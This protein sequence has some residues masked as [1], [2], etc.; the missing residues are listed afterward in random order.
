[1]KVFLSATE[2]YQNLF[3][4]FFYASY[5]IAN[6]EIFSSAAQRLKDGRKMFK[7]DFQDLSANRKTNRESSSLRLKVTLG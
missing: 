4:N 1:M 2:L 3:L 6:H 7:F 5:A